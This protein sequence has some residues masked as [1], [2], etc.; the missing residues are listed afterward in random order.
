MEVMVLNAYHVRFP[1][2]S[3][4]QVVFGA[5]FQVLLSIRNWDVNNINKITIKY[6]RTVQCPCFILRI[7]GRV[8]F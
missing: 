5:P 8:T 3:I 7:L 1:S 2:D 4:T 6:V